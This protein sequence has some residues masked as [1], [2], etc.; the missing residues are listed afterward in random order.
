MIA[1][2]EMNI[3]AITKVI[4]EVILVKDTIVIKTTITELIMTN[5]EANIMAKMTNRKD[6]L[7]AI[8]NCLQPVLLYK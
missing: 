5:R 3:E 4:A 6:N 2:I 1:I 8:N 7:L